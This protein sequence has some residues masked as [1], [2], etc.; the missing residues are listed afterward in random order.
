MAEGWYCFCEGGHYQY[1]PVLH[2][3]HLNPILP[4]L[5]VR[6]STIEEAREQYERHVRDKHPS[7]L[8]SEVHD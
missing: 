5:F 1:D 7:G 2:P 3:P 6:T 4:N 8:R